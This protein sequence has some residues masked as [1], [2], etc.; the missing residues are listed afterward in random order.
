MNS[1]GNDSFERKIDE[2]LTDSVKTGSEPRGFRVNLMPSRPKL[3]WLSMVSVLIVAIVLVVL[4]T[5]W[6]ISLNLDYSFDLS[7]ENITGFVT[8]KITVDLVF[9]LAIV[10]G[11]GGI[12]LSFFPNNKRVLNHIL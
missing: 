6:L 5:H 1:W 11:V 3:P 9:A 8:E 7:Y 4:G 12:L 2:L 10:L